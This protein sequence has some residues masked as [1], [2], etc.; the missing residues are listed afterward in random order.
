MMRVGY[1]SGAA[2]PG[3]TV[4][5]QDT[6]AAIGRMA[7]VL[8]TPRKTD[9]LTREDD[10]NLLKLLVAGA[11]VGIIVTTFRDQSGEWIVPGRDML[12]GPDAPLRGGQEPVLGYDGMNEET[13]QEWISGAGSDRN[14]IL[15]MIRYESANRGRQSVLATLVDQL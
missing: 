12:P 6:H 8:L 15:Q 10:M 9:S 14:S 13:L 7:N 3:C 11:A 1:S 5:M 2:E 4:P